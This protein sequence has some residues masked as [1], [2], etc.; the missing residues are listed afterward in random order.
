MRR[1]LRTVLILLAVLLLL[2]LVV[3][4][5]IPVP[6]LEETVPVEQLADPDSRFVRLYRQGYDVNGVSVHYKLAGEGRPGA[7][8]RGRGRPRRSDQHRQQLFLR[9]ADCHARH[10]GIHGRAGLNRHQSENRSSV[11][12][13]CRWCD[14][15]DVGFTLA[16]V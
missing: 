11:R 12:C 6:R 16:L 15:P 1:L 13:T 10:Q 8:P 7:D 9:Q 14:A 3:P 2:V 5:L 4:F